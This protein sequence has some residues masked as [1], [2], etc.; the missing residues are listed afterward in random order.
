[1][2]DEEEAI[3]ELMAMSESEIEMVPFDVVKLI[4]QVK[5]CKCYKRIRDYGLSPL[6]Y[7]KQHKGKWWNIDNTF[8]LCSKHWKFYEKL[9]KLYGVAHVQQKIIDFNKLPIQKI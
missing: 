9:V 8:L 7:V 6:Y 4:C 3:K 2:N 1:M 5:G